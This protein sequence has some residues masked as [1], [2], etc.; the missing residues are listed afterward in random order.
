[1]NTVT[2]IVI[3]DESASTEAQEIIPLLVRYLAGKCNG[4]RTNDGAGFNKLDATIGRD[5]ADKPVSAWNDYD[6]FRARRMLA[7]YSK[8]QIRDWWHLV[9]AV[10]DPAQKRQEARRATIQSHSPNPTRKLRIRE[11]KGRPWCEAV[12]NYGEPG[13]F[14]I[15]DA[16]KAIP[17]RLY[18]ADERVWIIP[19][20]ADALDSLLAIIDEYSF[21]VPDDVNALI[22]DVV[23]TYHN[24]IA[25][26][27]ADSHDIHIPGLNGRPFPFQLAGIAYARD[28]KKC[29][30]A[31]EM[32]LGKT[33][34]AIAT[35]QLLQ[36]F[37]LL[38]VVPASL[39]PNWRRELRKWLPSLS[40]PD[41]IATITGNFQ[42]HTLP[43]IRS[44]KEVNER[45]SDLQTI[46]DI[47]SIE[48]DIGPTGQLP[49]LG[50][51]I[52][53][54]ITTL[55]T[56][57]ENLRNS[58]GGNAALAS[59]HCRVAI[60]NYDILDSWQKFILEEFKPVMVIADEAHR[61][62]NLKAKR[63]TA[64]R[65]IAHNTDRVMMLTGTPVVNH[66]MELWSVLSILQYTDHFGSFKQYR[67][68]YCDTWNWDEHLERLKQLNKKCRSMFMV[69]RLKSQVLT[70]LPP[71]LIATVPLE[72][73]NRAEYERAE[74]DISGY[75]SQ[76]KSEDSALLRSIE[77]EADMRNLSG[78]ERH[79]FIAETM[80]SHVTATQKMAAINEALLRWEAL[81]QLAAKGKMARVKE[82]IDEFLE[83]GEKL[84]VF[85]THRQV[86]SDLAYMYNA[87]SIT[88]D[89]PVEARMNAVDRFQNDP[90]C[91]IIIGN[92][93]AMGEG[94]TLTA[95][96]NV[97][98]VQFGWNPKDQQQAEDRCHRI[99]QQ[100]TVN[101]WNLVAVGTIEEELV[102]LI[103]KK[104]EVTTAIQD[105]HQHVEEVNVFEELMEKI[106]E[107]YGRQ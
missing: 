44:L 26:S 10:A 46:A 102:A 88:G 98:F 5:L 19:F 79:D 2:R 107:K 71:K 97:A 68:L 24:K 93:Q 40:S 58:M 14:E 60:I 101:V 27:H 92:I 52:L 63:T 29:L 99:G 67:D 82:W 8:T 61:L 6:L 18:L 74:S 73:D 69:R 28:T 106:L 4:A 9:P 89:T 42:N 104:R 59:K 21:T 77:L 55:E 7:R 48:D 75:F 32:G 49:L 57:R 90:D 78:K 56:A 11:H 3:G 66:P 22:R 15:K 76:K 31:D 86:V 70:E 39:K 91:K 38:I 47:Q 94:L 17:G 54:A 105:G 64:F 45:I 23:G 62:K 37:P 1:M 81:K 30:I 16:I 53:S 103:E 25:L 13:F 87:P 85:A 83:S 12:L 51:G 35:A 80:R 20:S 95:A 34:Q 96:S 33:I 43:Q 50:S 41:S 72:I 84:V 100:D 36:A 65:H